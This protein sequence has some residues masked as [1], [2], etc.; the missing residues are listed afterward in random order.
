[1][2]FAAL[3]N[4]ELIMTTAKRASP[5]PINESIVFMKGKGS[6][7][8]LKKLPNNPNKNIPKLAPRI[9]DANPIVGLKAKVEFEINDWIAGERYV[10]KI[11]PTTSPIKLK[12]VLRIPRR[13]PIHPKTMVAAVIAISIK[14]IYLEK[15]VKEFY[16]ILN[17][18]LYS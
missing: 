5:K 15:L 7:T 14:F 10:P 17:I 9:I 13:K 16:Q 1:M 8:T 6:N 12:T 11:P 3:A 2:T 4:V 18:F